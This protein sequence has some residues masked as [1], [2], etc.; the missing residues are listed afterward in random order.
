[1]NINSHS[2]DFVKKISLDFKKVSRNDYE[3]LYPSSFQL[4]EQLKRQLNDGVFD[5]GLVK[6]C[7]DNFP[8]M[9]MRF[10]EDEFLDNVNYIMKLKQNITNAL[11]IGCGTLVYENFFTQTNIIKRIKGVDISK[12]LI[13]IGTKYFGEN[14]RINVEC[15]DFMNFKLNEY[16]DFVYCLSAIHWFSSP[17]AALEKLLKSTPHRPLIYL[18]YFDEFFGR[19]IDFKNQLEDYKYEISKHYFKNHHTGKLEYINRLIINN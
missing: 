14:E 13:D 17:H 2:I 4:F 3:T 9:E 19:K 18:T 7:F 11:S 5:S 12:G 16:Y 10:I 6:E 1:M 15:T 8:Y